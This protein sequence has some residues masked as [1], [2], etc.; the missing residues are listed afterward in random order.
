MGC[1]AEDI[2]EDGPAPSCGD[3]GW[4]LLRKDALLR[5]RRYP[6][7]TLAQYR[8]GE[9]YVHSIARDRGDSRRRALPINPSM[10]CRTSYGGV[11]LFEVWMAGDGRVYARPVLSDADPQVVDPIAIN[12]VLSS[13]E[14]CVCVGFGRCFLPLEFFN[15]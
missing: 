14:S 5:G 13:G 6:A 10:V 7:G 1:V 9:W 4:Y 2:H 12:L 8:D 11:S 3:N 15:W